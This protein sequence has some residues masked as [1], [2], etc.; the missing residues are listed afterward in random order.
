MLIQ[1]DLGS[2]IYQGAD[3]AGDNTRILQVYGDANGELTGSSGNQQGIMLN[4]HINQ[5]GTAGYQGLYILATETSLGSGSNRLIYA[6]TN[7]APA[8]ALDNDGSMFVAGNNQK[9]AGTNYLTITESV[10]FQGGGG[11]ASKT[12]AGSILPDGAYVTGVSGRVVTAGT[13][14]TSF[15]VGDGADVDLFA[16][17]ISP[18][19][20]TTFTDTAA[21]GN[22]SNPQIAAGEITVTGVGGNCV[23]LVVA[24]TVHY[25]SH[26]AA[27]SD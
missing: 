14:C 9:G 26:T 6:E 10:T 22:W 17:D 15:D 3:M 13:T 1:G 20:T 27:T 21:T 8:F 5:S 2:R 16:N 4:P 24:L 18:A 12:T 23:D 11:D 19:D 25:F 7:T